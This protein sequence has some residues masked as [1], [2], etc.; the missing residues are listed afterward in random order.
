MRHLFP[1]FL[2]LSCLLTFLPG[3]EPKEDLVQTSGSLEFSSDSVKFDTVFTTITTVTKRLWVYNR[4]AGAVKVERISLANQTSTLPYQLIVSGDAGNSASGVT[5]RGKDSLLVLVKA[6]LGD[7]SSTKP[8]L[9]ADQI[10]FRTNGNDQNVK[11]V[12]Y[13]Q[14]A[15][16]HDGEILPC[17]SIW[18]NDKPHVI[19]N[20]VQVNPGCTL[21]IM[22]GTRVYSHAGSAIIVQGRLVVNAPVD[23]QPPTGTTNDTVKA[24]NPNIVRF[25]GDR[26]ESFYNDG[27][28][29]WGG[30]VFTN[31]SRGNSI[32][33]AE[34]K[35]ATF[36][37]LIYNP[38]PSGSTLPDLTL[39]NTVI[40][41]ISGSKVSFAN[42]NAST[43]GGII[44]YSGAVTAT[45]C[46]FTNCGEYAIVGIGGT[47]DVNFCTIAN[48]T[49]SFHRETSSLTFSNTD[50]NHPTVKLPTSVS[51]RNSIV[52]G[53]YEDELFLQNNA[54][55]I[56]TLTISNCL[57]RTKEYQAT[58]DAPGKPGLA[59]TARR[60]LV[61]TDPL[62]VR[63]SLFSSLPDYRLQDASPA[64]TP[65][66]SVATGSIVPPRDL[67]NLQRPAPNQTMPS[68]GAYEHK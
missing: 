16:F 64:T 24:A 25:M 17:N 57:L 39:D 13:G 53:S 66:R 35:N 51:V 26:L 29:Q 41:N 15:Y 46:L 55:Y 28:G 43:G 38:A 20:S 33:Y 50:D 62:F 47:Y 67:L 49:P 59:S 54:D 21:R 68:L 14:N 40:R 23:Y 5:I 10:N 4:N 7:N 22:P 42:A 1:L 31:T 19:Y 63:T 65:R 3:C 27:P 34:I 12:A 56:G 18:R 37:A 6:V 44:S 61:N 45:N 48:Y 58:T 52:W 9:L 11:L 8:F 60:N 32:R 36:G 2:L 30:I